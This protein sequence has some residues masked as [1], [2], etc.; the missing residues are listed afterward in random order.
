MGDHRKKLAVELTLRPEAEVENFTTDR[1]PPPSSSRAET[2][3]S[4]QAVCL[5]AVVGRGVP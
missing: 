4:S 3:V 2:S 1:M 5:C